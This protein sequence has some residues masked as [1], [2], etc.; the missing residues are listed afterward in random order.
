MNK[1][2]IEH[3]EKTLKQAKCNH[4]AYRMLP[5][6]GGLFGICWVCTQCGIVKQELEGRK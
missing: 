3:I 2:T 4:S 1:L 5:I 6:W